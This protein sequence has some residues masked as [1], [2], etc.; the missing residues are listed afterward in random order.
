MLRVKENVFFL[1]LALC[2]LFN[3]GLKKY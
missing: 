2:A 3:N 1:T